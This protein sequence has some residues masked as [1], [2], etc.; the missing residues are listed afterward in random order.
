MEES[1]SEYT[2]DWQPPVQCPKCGCD[3]TRLFEPRDESSVYVC[4]I[5]HCLFEIQEG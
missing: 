2:A 4:N 1:E 5:C 3:D